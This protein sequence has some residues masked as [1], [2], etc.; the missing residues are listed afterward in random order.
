MNYGISVSLAFWLG[1]SST[2]SD[3]AASVNCSVKDEN[4]VTWENWAQGFFMTWCQACHSATATDRHGA[5]SGIDFDTETEVMAWK[6]RIV[7]RVLDQ[8]TMPLG[9]GLSTEDLELLEQYF[10]N[11]SCE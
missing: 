11:V 8:Q 1:C 2:K 3:S 6:E 10:N 9:G 5:P 4:M 7:V